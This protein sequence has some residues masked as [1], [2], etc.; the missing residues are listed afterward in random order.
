MKIP[1]IAL[2]ALAALAALALPGQAGE[3]R[4]L[5]VTV[6][7][8]PRAEGVLLI[9][10]Y[11]SAESFTANPLPGSPKIP[12]TSAADV[13]A[14]IKDLK[15]GS[16]AVAVVLDLNGNGELDRTFLGMPKEPLA[17]SVISEIP[18]GKPR[19]SAC[20]FEIQDTDVAL[21][22]PLVLK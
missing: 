17:F 7:N 6:T 14:T 10:V 9:G 21:T 13:S 15:P 1:S 19:F 20:A 22:I 4:A 8:I 16:Y 3:G 2:S 11:D 18:K 12:L 5:T